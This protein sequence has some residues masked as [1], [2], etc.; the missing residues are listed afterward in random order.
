ML[1]TEADC[2]RELVAVVVLVLEDVLGL[3]RRG[4]PWL[5][6]VHQLVPI[7]ALAVEMVMG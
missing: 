3:P 5:E 4:M 1:E 6:L 2:E 7:P